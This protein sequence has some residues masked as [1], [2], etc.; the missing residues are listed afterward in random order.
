MITTTMILMKVVLLLLML[1]VTKVA[2]VVKIG[3]TYCFSD[4]DKGVK[5]TK[6]E[7]IANLISIF[8]LVR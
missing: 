7:W 2:L 4:V 8:W 3:G 5:E 1:V 6:Q